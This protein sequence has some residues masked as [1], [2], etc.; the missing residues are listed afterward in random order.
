M[1]YAENDMVL[2]RRFTEKG[3]QRAF[4]EIVQRYAGMVFAV[5]RR[6][7]ND[8]ARAE[9]VSQ[10]T[11][12]R[13]MTRPE[14]VSQSLGGWLHCAATRLAVD[15]RRSETARRRREA[16]VAREALEAHQAEQSP[17]AVRWADIAPHLDEAL[18]QIEEPSR[19]LLIR[20]FLEGIQQQELARAEG[21]S[22]ATI[23]RRIKQAADE[24]R[25]EL[26]RRGVD[27]MPAALLMLWGRQPSEIPPIT[28]KCGLGKMAMLSGSRA[29]ATRR[30]Y[31]LGQRMQWGVHDFIA[32]RWAA[33]ALLLTAIIIAALV[34]GSR[35]LSFE[36]MMQR[37]T[38]PTEVAPS[39]MVGDA[40]R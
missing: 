5:C 14:S 37:G 40:P 9:E 18:A 7:L 13:L 27:V 21:V 1:E 33:A 39:A 2:L 24:L 29:A 16:E 30:L 20:H 6:I 3:D 31:S 36:R 38:A 19:L 22:A 11:F 23:S 17:Q 32:A 12:F 15:E 35:S 34:F 4:C 10:E 8:R 28:L 26:R 25:R